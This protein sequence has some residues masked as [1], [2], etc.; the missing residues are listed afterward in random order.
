MTT[1]EGPAR[2]YIERYVRFGFYRPAEVEQIVGED[3][4][5]GELPAKRIREL[6]KAEVARQKAEQGSWPEVT[7]CDRLDRAFVALR[8]QGILAVHNAGNTPSEGIAEISEQCRAAGSQ[9]SDL[10]GYCF[11]HR[12]EMEYALKYHKLGLA[13][14]DID[15]DDQRGVEVGKSIRSAV[16]AA[17]L[18]VAW[19]GSVNDKL[20]VTDFHWQRR[21]KAGRTWSNT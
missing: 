4:L 8:A 3:V 18:C 1:D 10:V 9:K 2:E 5:G 21:S 11:Y 14:G 20:E 17:G 15:G 13:Y 16:E 12:Q 7:D 19:T 6:V